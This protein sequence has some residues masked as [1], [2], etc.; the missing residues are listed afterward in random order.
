MLK[1]FEETDKENPGIIYSRIRLVRNWAEYP[2][3]GKLTEDQAREMVGRLEK[4]MRDFCLEDGRDY[5]YTLLQELSDLDRRALRERR[6]LNATLA[7]KKEP[8]G[9]ILSRDEKVSLVLNGDDH[10]Q[11]QFIAPGMH[12]KELWREA[13]R[14]DD[15]INERFNYAFDDKYGFLTAYP[16]NVG[17]GLRASAVVHLPSLSSGRKFSS[18]LGEM[19]RFGA[20]IRGLYGEE[21]ENYGSLYVVSNQKTLGVTEEEIVEIVEKV[22]RQLSSQ[23]KQVRDM[24]LSSDRLGC[25][26]EAFKSYGVLK[27]A[28]KLSWKDAMV[29]LSRLMAGAEDGILEFA[30][31]CPVFG[32]MLGIQKANLQK[33][34]E[35][36]L[37]RA[38]LDAARASYIR[39]EL[40]ELKTA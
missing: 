31:P 1:W 7:A 22:A 2:F 36:P 14:A 6:I 13:D 17:T 27:Y 34:S 29:F 9:L 20:S 10:I 3:S 12:L 19:S 33:L 25:Q 8:V 38:E 30:E 28:R 16:T 37:S 11:M 24:A 23:E 40:P 32:L 18:L 39:A 26:D 15:Y 35:R 5:D 21:N 4:G